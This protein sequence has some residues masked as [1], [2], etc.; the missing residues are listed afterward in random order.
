MLL[1]SWPFCR[2]YKLWLSLQAP[3]LATSQRPSSIS[4]VFYGCQMPAL[5][6]LLSH[7]NHRFHL[8]PSTLYSWCNTQKWKRDP[9]VLCAHYHCGGQWMRIDPGNQGPGG[10]RNTPVLSGCKFQPSP[11]HGHP[12]KMCLEEWPQIC[13]PWI[14]ISHSQS[15][16]ASQKEGLGIYEVIWVGG[17]VGELDSRLVASLKLQ[18][19][20][21]P[22]GLLYGIFC[23]CFT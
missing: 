4:C 10:I 8:C 9:F 1:P 14:C 22:F 15:C 19:L 20:S 17:E 16:N 3:W 18:P 13:V 5:C 7:Q 11:C 21:C 23:F 12:L 6:I 2:G